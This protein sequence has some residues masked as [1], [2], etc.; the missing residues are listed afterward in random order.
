LAPVFWDKDGILL[1]DYL[2]GYATITAKYYF[3]LL[4]KM[5][6]QLVSEGRGKLSKAIL[7][8][9]YSAATPHHILKCRAVAGM[10]TRLVCIKEAYFFNVSME[11]FQ[12]SFLK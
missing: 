6:H 11:N 2:E 4:D 7:F 1:V 10:E 3:A 9:Q 8:L 12:N 5:K